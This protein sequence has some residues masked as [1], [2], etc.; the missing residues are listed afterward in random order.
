MNAAISSVVRN[1]QASNTTMADK[2]ESE[3]VKS[4]EEVSGGLNNASETS[5]S[6]KYDTLELSRDY[7]EYKSRGE[8]IAL[9]DKTSQLNA[10]VLQNAFKNSRKD[11]I[12]SF[13]LYTYTDTELLEMVNKGTISQDQYDDEMASRKPFFEVG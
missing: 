8:N 6:S 5:V 7:L 9:Q 10:T 3:S 13:D 11:I 1:Q 4:A 2:V 12:Y